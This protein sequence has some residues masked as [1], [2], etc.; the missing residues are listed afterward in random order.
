MALGASLEIKKKN[1]TH[2]HTHMREPIRKAPTDL[3]VVF[4][5][6]A[7]LV[8]LHFLA[9]LSNWRSKR[10]EFAIKALWKKSMSKM[11]TKKMRKTPY[12]FPLFFSC[13]FGYLSELELVGNQL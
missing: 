4:N 5:F 12:C 7:R 3:G 8:F 13:V 10:Q 1:R 2:T 9:V 11:I 6:L